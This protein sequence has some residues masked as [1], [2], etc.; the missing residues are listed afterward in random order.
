M[1]TWI[2]YQKDVDKSFTLKQLKEFSI[3]H[4][5]NVIVENFCIFTNG[6]ITWLEQ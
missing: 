6:V 1:L 3:K 4:C 5:A 2:V